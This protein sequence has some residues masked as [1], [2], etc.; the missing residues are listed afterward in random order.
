MRDLAN[1]AEKVL[2]RH[3]K[4]IIS[5]EFSQK[6]LAEM[7]MYIYAMICVLSRVST[8][9][10]QQG[11]D[12]CEYEL[13]IAESFCERARRKIRRNSRA[14]DKNDD[15]RLKQIASVTYEKAGYSPN[16]F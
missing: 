13:W 14:M 10:E 4:E 12:A 6:R 2:R 7:T 9:I 16:I 3:G 15:E 1:Q 11:V 8:K 5:K